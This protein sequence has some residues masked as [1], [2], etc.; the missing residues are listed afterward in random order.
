MDNSLKDIDGNILIHEWKD[1]LN[2]L[3]R[4]NLRLIM[5]ANCLKS[6][7]LNAKESKEM[8]EQMLKQRLIHHAG[9]NL[10]IKSLETSLK[11]VE[12]YF[13]KEGKIEEKQK[14]YFENFFHL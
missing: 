6:M 5:T 14:E 8:I 9:L 2:K 7:M 11:I 1:E 10:E 3:K 4:D 12:Y 13:K